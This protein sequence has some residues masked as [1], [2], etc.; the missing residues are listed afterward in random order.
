[1]RGRVTLGAAAWRVELDDHV[2]VVTVSPAG[3]GVVA[4]SLGGDA[5][6]LD[7]AGDVAAKLAHHDLGV[8]TAAWRPDGGGFAVG[9]QD[10]RVRA[11]DA[12]G[13]ERWEL[14]AGAWV[15]ALAW[16]P[17]GDRL[18]AGAGRHLSL[19]DGEGR[20][21]RLPAEASTV[22][23]AAWSV[24]GRRVGAAAYGGVSWY[25]PATAADGPVR[26]FEW[27]GSLLSLA[28][29][30]EGRWACAGAQD[31]SI[32]I[33]RLWSGDDLEMSGYPAKV[34]H[35][36][37]EPSGR[38]MAASCLSE[39]TV[40]DFGGKGPAGR[41]P[42]QGSAHDRHIAA[43][44]WSP[45]GALLATGGADGRVV[46]WPLPRRSGAELR[47]L[48]SVDGDAPVSALAWSADGGSL[49]VG[50]GDGTVEALVRQGG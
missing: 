33:W 35:L 27:K 49:L 44:A 47:P 14:A 15:T 31:A 8:L 48:T 21:T 10:G 32:H 43:L 12:S 50:R 7:A 34:E 42:A 23:A 6:L 24:D 29:G 38:W 11:Y 20:S 30:P 3:T 1:M 46:L 2:E 4:G 5:L 37:F 9:G 18:A 25:E 41:G 17:D 39:L 45:D 36:A 19:V 28:V 16:S 13:V 22:T 26:R 40:W